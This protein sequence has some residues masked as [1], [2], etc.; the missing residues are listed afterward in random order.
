MDAIFT[1]IQ[2]IANNHQAQNR[3]SLIHQ[4]TCNHMI[5][6]NFSTKSGF[7]FVLLKCCLVDLSNK[8]LTRNLILSGPTQVPEQFMSQKIKKKI[9]VATHRNQYFKLNDNSSFQPG[10]DNLKEKKVEEKRET[11]PKPSSDQTVECI[12]LAV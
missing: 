10:N 4:V 3:F 5:M 1:S 11:Y 8:Q 2:F 12:P 6:E 9:I 7:Q